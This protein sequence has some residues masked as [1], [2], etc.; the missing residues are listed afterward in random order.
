MNIDTFLANDSTA[1]S[2]NDI[3]TPMVLVKEMLDAIPRRV[4]K[5]GMK[6]LDPCVGLGNFLIGMQDK[7]TEYG[8]SGELFGTDIN[9]NR[10]NIAKQLLPDATIRTGSFLDMPIEL[11]DVV[12]A[13]PPYAKITDGKRASK[14][15]NI[16]PEFILKS[17]SMLK[18]GGAVVF[19][20]PTSWMSLSDRNIVAEKLTALNMVR[21]D[22]N[23]SKKWFPGVGSSF[24]WFVCVNES[25]TMTH[26]TG[27]YL[28]HTFD[29]HVVLQNERF[30]PLL[31][32]DMAIRIMRKITGGDNKL[33]I[34]TSSDL[35]AYTRKSIIS[36][37][38]DDAHP[39]KLVHTKKQTKWSQRPH[40]FQDGVKVF[41]CLTSTYETWIDSCGMT[42]SAA[43]VRCD[44]REQALD[45]KKT[46]D[47]LPFVFAISITRYGN[48]TNIRVLQ[49]LSARDD[50]TDDEIDYMKK[51]ISMM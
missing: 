20:C 46:L 1:V 44:N 48:F 37:H 30:I 34:E 31:C 11:F 50:Y 27:K 9:I 43:F 24:S 35:H 25:H 16:F 47:S 7:F 14:N 3:T 10:V 23:S 51:F 8:V 19:I 22:I 12:V 28:K 18:E 33:C 36:D 38:Q 21:L 2:R 26:V 17:L 6:V 29:N 15:H 32:T 42:Q 13:N 45:I 49:Q 39:Y 4:F 40:K 5:D 41:I